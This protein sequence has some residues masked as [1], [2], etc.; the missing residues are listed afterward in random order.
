MELIKVARIPPVL[1]SPE[2]TVAKAAA[3]MVEKQVGA[4]VVVNANKHVLGIFTE[5][6]NL[7][8]VTAS[9]CDPKTTPISKVM[10]APVSTA[11]PGMSVED[12]LTLMIRSHFRHL[13]IVDSEKRVIGIVS[14][15]Y[16]LM[17]RLGEKQAAVDILEAYV[18]A[19][20]P[21]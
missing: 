5:R 8:K 6:D 3:L 9:G 15:R 16:L 17:R 19:G 12:A 11:E 13:P 2:M 21:G 14:I 18:G 1:A 10:S 7:I 20:G 4:V